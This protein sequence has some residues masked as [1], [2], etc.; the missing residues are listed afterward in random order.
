MALQ[1]SGLKLDIFCSQIE[2]NNSILVIAASGGSF[3]IINVRTRGVYSATISCFYP[4]RLQFRSNFCLEKRMSWV[5]HSKL[6]HALHVYVVHS[7]TRFPPGFL[8]MEM[9]RHP[10]MKVLAR[11]LV[12]PSMDDYSHLPYLTMFL[13]PVSQVPGSASPELS[14]SDVGDSHLRCRWS[15]VE[16]DMKSQHTVILVS[17]SKW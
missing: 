17:I 8:Q 11:P 12:I 9:P 1:I 7:Q 2:K 14:T 6:H 4:V 13:G 15:T 10:C 3:P 16:G 5:Y